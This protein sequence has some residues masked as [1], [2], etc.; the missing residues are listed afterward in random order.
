MALADE[1]ATPAELDHLSACAAC[2]REVAAFRSLRAAGLRSGGVMLDAPI[3]SWESLAPALRAA[4]VIRGGATARGALLTRSRP[5]LAAAAAVMLV[6]GGVLLGRLTAK[7]TPEV[8]V[9]RIE[10]PPAG[11]QSAVL[12]TS[13]GAPIVSVNDALQIMQ[14]AEHDYRAAAAFI[15]AQDPSTRGDA[16]RYRTRLAALDRVQDAVR[17][18]VQE[19]PDDPM[20]NQYLLSTRSARAVTL[21]QLST[22]LPSNVRLASW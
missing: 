19:S 20:L 16:E 21:Q 10:S 12:Q 4:G 3:T 15:A 5:W 7:P 18:A 1:A 2:A 13:A 22:T 17:E 11:V 9:A 14:R 6:A 8:N